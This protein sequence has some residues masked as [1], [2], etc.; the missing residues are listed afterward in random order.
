MI[1]TDYYTQKQ[2]GTLLVITY[3]TENKYII[4]SSNQNEYISAIDIGTF[5]SVTNSYKPKDYIYTESEKN[6][7]EDN[8]GEDTNEIRE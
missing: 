3:S 5:D 1:K 8:K 7:E 2:D 6:I 4:K